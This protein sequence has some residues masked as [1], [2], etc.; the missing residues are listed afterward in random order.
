M[1]ERRQQVILNL[2]M[3]VGMLAAQ[4]DG[5]TNELRGLMNKVEPTYPLTK[6]ILDPARAVAAGFQSIR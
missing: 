2:Q 5:L 4:N 1:R 3:E 6:Q